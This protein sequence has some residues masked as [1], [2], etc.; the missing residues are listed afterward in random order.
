[1]LKSYTVLFLLGLLVVCKACEIE[2]GHANE[3][4]EIEYCFAGYQPT[5]N[6]CE[7]CPIG[8]YSDADDNKPCRVCTNKPLNAEYTRTGQD[9]FDCKYECPAGTVG[10][11]CRTEFGFIWPIITVV[12]AFAAVAYT[13]IV[14]R[15]RYIERKHK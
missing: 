9:S 12:A 5:N 3:A 7:R 13:F 4:C 6:I 8:Y 15:Q 11:D 2:N 14:I 10:R 1:M